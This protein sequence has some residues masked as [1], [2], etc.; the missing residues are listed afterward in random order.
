MNVVDRLRTVYLDGSFG[1]RK[2]HLHLFTPDQPFRDLVVVFHGV[3]GNAT[4]EEG[5]KYGDL[6][7]MI[8][9]RGAAAAVVETSRLRRDR[10]AFGGDKNRWAV[11]AFSGKTFAQEIQDL[12]WAV[13]GATE[14]VE[15]PRLW[16]WG[17][18]LGGIGAMLIASG[19]C[20]SLGV[21]S[22]A[23]EV[24]GVVVSGTGDVLRDTADLG[25]L[26]LPILNNLPD[27]SLLQDAA[28]NLKASFFASFRGT[29]DDLF[30]VASCRRLV[31]L[32]PLPEEDK[33]MQELPGV[34]HSFR[35]MNGQPSR[36]PLRLMVDRVR[37]RWG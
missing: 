28:R 2:V 17:F 19:L 31:D 37:L 32:V 22:P 26:K 9:Q 16:L 10:Q 7:R 13:R 6:G 4:P 29:E 8:A 25:M 21:D 15:A 24:E 30:G 23:S 33:F 36:E 14:E 5:N 35:M 27:R 12:A 34:D 1:D 18:S 11:E 3:H 20:S